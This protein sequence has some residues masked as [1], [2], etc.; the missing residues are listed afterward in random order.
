MQFKRN[1]DGIKK[2][3]LDHKGDPILA[4]NRDVPPL[5]D[6]QVDEVPILGLPLIT[7]A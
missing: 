6:N 5:G 1:L 2:Y 4:K 3:D 7:F